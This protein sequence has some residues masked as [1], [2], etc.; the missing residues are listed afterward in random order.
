M[1]TCSTSFPPSTQ[2]PPAPSL[3]APGCLQQIVVEHACG[4]PECGVGHGEGEGEGGGGSRASSKIVIGCSRALLQLKHIWACALGG[5]RVLR[6][7][8]GMMMMIMLVGT[9]G[10]TRWHARENRG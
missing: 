3:H 9:D 6:G 10:L 7:S 2:L 5:C 1:C 8:S 4:S